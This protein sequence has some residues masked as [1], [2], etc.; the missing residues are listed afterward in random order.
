MW[1]LA[2]NGLPLNFTLTTLSQFLQGCFFLFRGKLPFAPEKAA[3]FTPQTHESPVIHLDLGVWI[4]E[5]C[6]GH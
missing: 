3:S 1:I 2:R 4:R 6:L 5:D